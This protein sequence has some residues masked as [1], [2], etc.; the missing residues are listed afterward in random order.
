MLHRD[1]RHLGGDGQNAVLEDRLGLLGLEALGQPQDALERADVQ[2]PAVVLGARLI[3][4]GLELAGNGQDVAI[5]GDVD[6][7]GRDAWE[8]RLDDE[9]R[10]RR[11]SAH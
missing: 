3:L 10:L 9:R 7:F 8:R 5:D 11:G 4:F 2:L 1:L 6:V